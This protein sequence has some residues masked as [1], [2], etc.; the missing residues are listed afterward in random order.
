MISIK[1]YRHAFKACAPVIHQAESIGQFLLDHYGPA[2][3]VGVQVFKGAPSGETEIT[4]NLEALLANDA[5]EYVILE[6]PGAGLE[7]M[8][9]IQIILVVYSVATALMANKPRGMPQNVNRQQESPNN[10]LSNRENQVRLGQ[11]VEDIYG[12]VRSIPSLMMPTYQ[13][14]VRNQKFEYG[15]Y[16]IGRGYYDITDLR[17]GDTLISEITG[18]SAA[19]YEPFTSPNSGDAPVIQIGDEII[20]PILNVVRSNSVDGITLKAPNELVL[21][22]VAN[23]VFTKDPTGDT[24]AQQ[25]NAIPNVNT[26]AEEGQTVIV[27]MD[28]YNLPPVSATFEFYS[29]SITDIGATSP[30]IDFYVGDEITITFTETETESG[31]W[32]ITDKLSNNQ[33]LVSGIDFGTF[34]EVASITKQAMDFS[35]S[36]TIQ[37]VGDG[38]IKLEETE[39]TSTSPLISAEVS[40]TPALSGFTDWATLPSASRTEVW[41]NVIAQNGLYRDNGAKS[42]ASVSYEIEIEQLNS[43]LTPAGIVETITGTLSGASADEVADTVER[44][45][46]WVGPARVR[47]R[48]TSD[49]DL[50]FAGTVIDEIKFG[51]L[52]SVAPVV[53]ED[54]GN[55]TTVHTITKATSRATA[56]KTRQLR[57]LA[58][59]KLPTF[60]GTTFSGAFDAD[61]R[62]VSGTISAT[63]KIVD[64]IAAVAVDPKIGRREIAEIDMAQIWGVQQLLD[65]W[66][67]ETGQYNYT[68]D[69]D[70][71]SFEETI[72]QIANAAFCTAYRQNGKIRLSL[73]RLQP[74]ST[75]L[76]THRNKPPNSETITRNFANDAEYDGVDFVYVDPD[77]DQSETIILPLDGNYTKL[78]KFELPGVRSFAQAW[79]RANREYY[80]LKG[81][82][83]QIETSTTM[84]ARFAVPNSRVDIVDNTRFKSFDG[85]VI[86]QEGMLLTLSQ[87]V[88]FVPEQNHSILLMKRNGTMQSIPVTP[89]PENNQVVLSMLPSE[90]IVTEYGPDGVRTIFSFAADLKR[91]AQAWLLQEIDV[92]DGQ[93]AT[94]KAVNYSPDYYQADSQPIPDKAGV[95]N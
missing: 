81:L 6:S 48:R 10:A 12:K 35:G 83:L 74:T 71:L 64:I 13:K 60:N 2:P 68:L 51:D 75:A 9:I 22:N 92:T 3:S 76:F 89:G 55:K 69:S 77:S 5:P 57:C 67:A 61:G 21:P 27:S 4:G 54:F 85:E 15:Y 43:D 80:K 66:H 41:V 16:C 84:D 78:R 7:V 24:I 18:A 63:S 17:D 40:I 30:F 36:Y 38:S 79:L 72:I 45:T 31:P 91:E 47:M 56:L 87:K 26:I 82:R 93:Y 88:E 37:D 23:Y 44:V 42:I 46:A 59:R 53:Q 95:I 52:Y 62:H 94:L 65:A 25:A 73:D 1:L 33:I 49:L 8:T 70:N 86:K 11:R 32:P 90:A 34:V 19:V 58:A 28:P 50:G 14:Y 20:D 39:F 29:N